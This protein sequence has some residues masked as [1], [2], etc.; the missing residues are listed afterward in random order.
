MREVGQLLDCRCHILSLESFSLL[1]GVDCPSAV[2]VRTSHERRISADR[3]VPV[4]PKRAKH[5][6][7]LVT[8]MM[9]PRGKEM[10]QDKL[11]M[12]RASAVATTPVQRRH[13]RPTRLFRSNAIV[14]RSGS[15][16]CHS[17]DLNNGFVPKGVVF[18]FARD[19]TNRVCRTDAA[20][21]T[22]TETFW[23]YC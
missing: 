23:K 17:V 8:V 13:C 11:R 15:V 5:I 6:G 20:Q 4:W 7:V 16:L 2:V 12:V 21:G 10:T 3:V 22:R 14:Q 1:R 18:G 19:D 9:I